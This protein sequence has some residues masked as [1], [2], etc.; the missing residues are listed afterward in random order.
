MTGT[1]M[2]VCICQGITDTAIKNAVDNG[3]CSLDE[4]SVALGVANN[5]GQ[6]AALASTIIDEQLALLA[7]EL[8]YAAA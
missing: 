1:L 5:C 2:Y 7:D 6:C 8:S 3:A 4:I